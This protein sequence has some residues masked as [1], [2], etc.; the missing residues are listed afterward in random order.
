[1]WCSHPACALQHLGTAGNGKE[2]CMLWSCP[3]M[4]FGH[5]WG[6]HP[7]TDAG[8][9]LGSSAWALHWT[10]VVIALH[11]YSAQKSETLTIITCLWNTCQQAWHSLLPANKQNQVITLTS[12]SPKSVRYWQRVMLGK[13][14]RSCRHRQEGGE[15]SSLTYRKKSSLNQSLWC[16]FCDLLRPAFTKST[17]EVTPIIM[18]ESRRFSLAH[19][20]VCARDVQTNV[21]LECAHCCW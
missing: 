10:K 17:A 18:H 5:A 3:S 13:E 16:S 2:R 6:T 15:K 12:I 9:L 11:S 8:K 1:M 19:K 21:V 20:H 7:G 4:E 14:R